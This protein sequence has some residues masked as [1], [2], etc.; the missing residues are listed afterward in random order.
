MPSK[1]NCGKFAS[2]NFEGE[3]PK[4]CGKCKKPS[5]ILI[6]GKKCKCGESQPHF[7]YKGE[8]PEY[9]GK[10]KKTGMIDVKNKKCNC[11]KVA[12][13]NFEGEIP[14]YCGKCKEPGMIL[15][16]GKKCKCGKFA[17]FNFEGEKP[18]YCGKCK[19]PGMIL[20]Y[21]KKRKST[22]DQINNSKKRK[23]I[24]TVQV[25]RESNEIIYQENI[26]LTTDNPTIKMET[27]EPD[28]SDSTVSIKTEEITPIS[29]DSEGLMSNFEDLTGNNQEPPVFEETDCLKK[30]PS[31]SFPVAINDNN[32][33][34]NRVICFRINCQTEFCR[35]CKKISDTNSR[36]MRCECQR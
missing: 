19:K 35:Y 16:Y 8:K 24:N 33:G 15:I 29:F 7:N 6:Y 25:K 27:I 17:S 3:K 32:R 18:E 5:M 2:F 11:G 1:C 23:I 20:I 22:L 14:E 13:F 28:E 10:C 4:Y 21:G 26:D 9:C 12:S 36:H 30:C 31:C 34:C